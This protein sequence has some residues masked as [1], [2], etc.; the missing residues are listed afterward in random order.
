MPAIGCFASR[1][2][3]LEQGI[4]TVTGNQFCLFALLCLHCS[5]HCSC[6]QVDFNAKNDY[7]YINNYKI[8]Q[9]AFTKLGIDKVGICNPPAAWLSVRNPPSATWLSCYQLLALPDQH[10]LFCAAH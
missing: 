10:T 9:A 4:D 3:C 6:T 8:L 5:Q 7:E 1:L 2:C